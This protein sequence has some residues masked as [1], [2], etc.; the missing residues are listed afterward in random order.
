MPETVGLIMALILKRPMC[1]SCIAIQ[2]GTASPVVLESSLDRI[3]QV[4]PV[5]REQ[6]RC[7]SCGLNTT[8]ISVD[9][10]GD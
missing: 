3:R 7:R 6:G 4:L 1:V 9:R 5:R 8:V 2:T 10:P